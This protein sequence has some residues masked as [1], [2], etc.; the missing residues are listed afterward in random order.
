MGERGT[1]FGI[2]AAFR[3]ATLFGRTAVKPVVA[4][5]ALWY[6]L[7]DRAVVAASRSWL[8]R[9]SGRPV[10]FRDVFRHV[11][12]FAQVTL[13]K[14]FLLTDHTRA[15]RFSR[16]GH[17]LLAAQ[18]A[19]GR[20]AILI[21]AHLGSYEA[22]RAASDEDALEIEILGYFANARMIN[23]LLAELNPKSAARVIHLG[24]DPV[25]VMARV[26]DSLA[27]GRF[28]AVMADRTG[29]SDRV[30]RVPFFGQ[31]AAFASGP[32]L[33]AS[34]LRCP[35]YLVFGLYRAPN[36]Y[37]LHCERFAER[38]ELPRRTRDIALRDW[39]GRYA[40]RVEH[41]ARQA[42]ENWFNFFDLWA[43]P[44]PPAS[45]DTRPSAA[46]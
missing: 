32:F 22:M 9:V 17:E 26:N 4:A 40:A 5:I 42:P 2:R 39:V 19:T 7:F 21:G 3:F 43:T 24:D 27:A 25:G 23:T 8:Q 41:F 46:P 30:I 1:V 28:I 33:M 29:L 45:I 15:L 13:D 44:A 34:V 37:E 10:G 18:Q 20:G 14:V 35:V 6:V 31:A 12:T 11:R 36:R 38:I 16:T